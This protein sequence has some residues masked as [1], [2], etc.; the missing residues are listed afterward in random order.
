M[1]SAVSP[2]GGSVVCTAPPRDEHRQHTSSCDNREHSKKAEITIKPADVAGHVSRCNNNYTWG[3]ATCR[4]V[5]LRESLAP[6]CHQTDTSVT[7]SRHNQ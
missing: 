1:L 4:T 3:I 7:L 6:A 2:P 5:S